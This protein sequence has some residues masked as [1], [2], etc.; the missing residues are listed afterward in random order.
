M[1]ES[2][3]Q[4]SKARRISRWLVEAGELVAVR[5]SGRARSPS[6]VD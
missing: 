3:P 2:Y 6:G 1:D 4:Y 5:G